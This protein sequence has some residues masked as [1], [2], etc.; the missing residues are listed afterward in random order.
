MNAKQIQSKSMGVSIMNK[1][2]IATILTVTTGMVVAQ[3]AFADYDPVGSALIG[4]VAGAVIGHA[5]G[6]RNGAYVGAAL[7]GVGG[8]VIASNQ[9]P[10]YGNSYSEQ[11]TVYERPAY[12]RPLQTT[13][14]TQPASVAYYPTT[15]YQQREVAYPV[16]QVAYDGGGDYGYDRSWHREWREHDGGDHGWQ[17]RDGDNRDW[18]NRSNYSY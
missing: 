5:V 4:G 12:E 9:R 7:G 13:Y 10:Y 8:A 14:Y 15:Y 18:H 2:M 3:P 16:R 1:L 6:G 17:G 11:R